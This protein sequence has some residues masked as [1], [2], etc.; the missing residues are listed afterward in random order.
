MLRG[1]KSQQTESSR[2]LRSITCLRNKYVRAKRETLEERK[3]IKRRDGGRGRRKERKRRKIKNE[4]EKWGRD[5]KKQATENAKRDKPFH[6]EHQH[7]EWPP[8]P[9][10]RPSFPSL[11]FNP[12]KDYFVKNIL[13]NI[14][15][16]RPSNDTLHPPSA[17]EDPCHAR[18][19]LET[20]RHPAA[21]APPSTFSA[22]GVCPHVCVFV[23][24]RVLVLSNRTNTYIFFCVC[25]SSRFPIQI[26]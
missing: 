20:A 15:F 11:D 25:N 5:K 1:S 23:F 9:K 13:K 12:T 3:R 7:Q 19:S 10:K 4:E 8:S 2:T 16:S 26:S 18:G 24:A 6:T 14:N 21:P 22:R 17:P